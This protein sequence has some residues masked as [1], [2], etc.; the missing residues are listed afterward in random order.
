MPSG[1]RVV[2]DIRRSLDKYNLATSPDFE[3]VWFDGSI[4]FVKAPGGGS[5]E[6]LDP[7]V[8]LS[9]LDAANRK[10]LAVAPDTTLKRAVTQS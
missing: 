1:Y 8:R 7:T 3:S 2:N 10:P 9:Q 4:S 6:A 5:E